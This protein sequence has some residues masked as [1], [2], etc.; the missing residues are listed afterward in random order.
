MQRYRGIVRG[1]GWYLDVKRRL[2]EKNL[3]KKQ[4]GQV[5]AQ[6]CW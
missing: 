5:V 4:I 6:L 3:E 2:V 1:S